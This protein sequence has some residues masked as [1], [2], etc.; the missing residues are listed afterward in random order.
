MD[1]LFSN[2]EYYPHLFSPVT[3]RGKYFK[4][5]IIASP[6]GCRLPVLE[7][8]GT[9]YAHITELGIKYYAGPAKGGA[10][11]VNIMEGGVVPGGGGIVTPSYNLFKPNTLATMHLFTD[12]VHAYGSLASMELS[13]I[14]QW[15]KDA[16]GPTEKTLYTGAKVHELTERDIDEI[17]RYYANAANMVKRGGFDLIMLHG[18]HNWLLSQFMSPYENKRTD[19]FGGSPENR[20]RLTSMVLDAI[21]D[22]VGDS[23]AIELRVSLDDFT[24]GAINKEDCVEM[25]KLIEDKVDII[26]CSAGSRHIQ[27]TIGIQ[28][29]IYY[30]PNAEKRQLAAYA[31]KHLK[32]PIAAI[33]N[34]NDPDIAEEII[35][36]GEADFVAG[37]R[38]FMADHE[39]GV[40][41]REG[42][43]EDIRPC[44]RCMRCL[45]ISASKINTARPGNKIDF[46]NGTFHWE[47]SVNPRE[48]L[49]SVINEIPAPKKQKK[50]LVVGGGPAGMEAA[51]DS[52]E[53]GH[54]VVLF[55][56]DSVLGG[57]LVHSDYMSFKVDMK[58]FKD[59]LIRQVSK[60]P[61]IELRM[62]THAT[63]EMCEQENADAVI[64]A[65]GSKPIIP[66]IPGKETNNTINAFDFFGC[67][68]KVGEKIVIIGGGPVGCETALHIAELGKQD[69]TVIEMGDILMPETL[70]VDRYYTLWFMEKE[71]DR[72]TAVEVNKAKDREHPIK[73]MVKTTCTEITPE[74]VRVRDANGEEKLIPADTVVLAIGMRPDFKDRDSFYGTAFDVI[75]AG[76]CNGRGQTV[77]NATSS[78]F[79][80]A[81]QL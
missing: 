79:F 78:G 17:V 46:E 75:N 31:K 65:I 6:H 18:G 40:K 61:N 39:W 35:A 23:L 80:A 29:S 42:R 58:R 77:Y 74:G 57:Q 14:G 43:K 7:I 69:I 25:L 36:N 28:E 54:K 49:P 72:A 70:Y 2:K 27:P 55:E 59:Y 33:G 67:D 32:V 52:A 8:D 21:R 60:H 76:D 10:A 68:P 63:P 37:A 81:Q 34:I 3:L 73:S 41:A 11:V 13:H 47:C 19:R 48:L 16:V 50:V 22:R 9:G 26:Q 12:Y 38:N 56:E 1:Q 15:A 71:Y 45:D 5:R 24:D 30:M 44:I 51:L 62:N 53:R 64:V 20:I 4:N 66:R